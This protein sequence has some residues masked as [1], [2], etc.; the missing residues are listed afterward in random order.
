VLNSALWDLQAD[1]NF[2]YAGSRSGSF[3]GLTLTGFA[4]GG[5]ETIYDDVNTRVLLRVTEAVTPVP[6]PGPA[7]LL[8]AGLAVLGGLARRRRV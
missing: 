8:L 6:E 4:T 2:T 1:A 3:A 5:F 7:A